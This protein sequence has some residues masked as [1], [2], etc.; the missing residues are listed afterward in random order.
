MVLIA[1]VLESCKRARE[2]EAVVLEVS[3]ERTWYGIQI[4]SVR[5]FKW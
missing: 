1:H 3:N 4:L 5:F 2:N